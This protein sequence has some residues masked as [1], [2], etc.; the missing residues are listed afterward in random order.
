MRGNRVKSILLRVSLIGCK[1][2]NCSTF[3]EEPQNSLFVLK[4][5]KRRTPLLNNDEEQSFPELQDFPNQ[6]CTPYK[7]AIIG[8]IGGYIVRSMIRDISCDVCGC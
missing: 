3:E 5:T 7:E 6:K 1:Q 4:W 8:Y 2:G